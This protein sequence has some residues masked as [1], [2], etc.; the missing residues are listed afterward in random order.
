MFVTSRPPLSL[1]G[2]HSVACFRLDCDIL[3]P[4][5]TYRSL[6]FFMISSA[7]QI[8]PLKIRNYKL[9]VLFL[10]IPSVYHFYIPFSPTCPCYHPFAIFRM[11]GFLAHACSVFLLFSRMLFFFLKICPRVRFFRFQ[12][13]SLLARPSSVFFQIFSSASDSNAS[14]IHGSS[15]PFS[16]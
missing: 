16:A 6:N 5:G 1:F 14:D 8:F 3:C 9:F 13:Q 10:D 2:I 7:H 11:V 15:Y 4:L 12:L